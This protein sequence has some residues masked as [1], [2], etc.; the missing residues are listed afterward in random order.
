MAT[1][2]EFH[3]ALIGVDTA[4]I[5]ATPL[6]RRLHLAADALGDPDDLAT[7]DL[8]DLLLPVHDL[9]TELDDTDL[10]EL[11]ARHLIELAARIDDTLDLLETPDLSRVR[12]SELATRIRE[13]YAAV[14]RLRTAYKRL[15][16][17]W[18]HRHPTN[19]PP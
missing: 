12:T 19:N 10:S 14:I 4:S 6:G 9:L 1:A 7:D 16:A 3:A 13:L 17:A 8:A 18:L 2:Q 11:S 5:P 15:K